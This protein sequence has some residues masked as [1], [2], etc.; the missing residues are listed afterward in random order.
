MKQTFVARLNN[1]KEYD[2]K[3]KTMLWKAAK[4]EKVYDNLKIKDNILLLG[5]KSGV[6]N[7]KVLIGNISKIDKAINFVF[8]N[9][10]E[11]ECTN[12]DLLKIGAFFP[13][14]ASQIK[15]TTPPFIHKREINI[16]NVKKEIN[17]KTY[18]N[19]YV[20]K[21]EQKYLEKIKDLKNNDRVVILNTF[22]RFKRAKL[23]INGQLVDFP[24]KTNYNAEGL[25]IEELEEAHKRSKNGKGRNNINAINRLKESFDQNGF[26]IFDKFDKYYDVLYNY[27]SFNNPNAKKYIESLKGKIEKEYSKTSENNNY[28]DDMPINQILYGPPGTGK[29]Y[30]TIEKAIKIINPEYDFNQ[31][32]EIIK[33]EFSRLLKNGQIVFTTFHQSMSYE[34]F[35]EGIKPLKPL[36][37]D[38]FMK[39]DV[40]PGIFY[41]ICEKAKSNYQNAKTENKEKLSFEEAF[42]QFK[43]TWENEP[44]MKFPLKTEGYEF[45]IIG[46]TN[47]SIQFKKASGG[48][49]H[50]LSIKTLKELYYGKEY[51]FNQGIGIYYPAVLNKIQ[52]FKGENRTEVLL[53]NYILII[54]EI[55]RGNVSQIF[56]ELITLIEEDKRLGKTE[57]LEITLPYSKEKFGVPP[58]LYIIGTMNT[59]DRSVEALD[60][61][62]RRRFSFIEMPPE[63]ELS[64]LE[65]EI[66]G[67]KLKDIL[68]TINNRIEV[69]LDKDHRIGHSYFMFK[70]EDN[71]VSKTREA[72]NKNIIPLLQEYFY[73][74]YGKIGLALG[75]GFVEKIKV[76]NDNFSK[77]AKFDYDDKDIISDLEN[78]IIY[79]TKYPETEEDFIK[80]IED[81][82]T[83]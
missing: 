6:L 73:G 10:E 16:D 14:Y 52:S 49:A 46:F 69:L 64:E 31:S 62:L 40:Q 28:N 25:T 33:E 1:D 11:L 30:E 2:R 7:G 57:E 45:T 12:E 3:K 67:H 56:G 51:N 5:S 74:D 43:D 36:S 82:M 41:S 15:A 26:Y 53:N 81:L 20:F 37:S 42:E 72:F 18:I 19:F 27:T 68:I 22:N 71:I 23:F 80:A 29:T 75:E 70:D 9:I 79:K 8:S 39:Y 66:K 4:G 17:H 13:E 21:S 32:R 47:T 58:N 54:D 34:D 63:Y 83:N 50:T 35:I 61:A 48:T 44:G 78:R 59:A 65:K 38:A 60:T 77:F 55:N 24:D 76:N